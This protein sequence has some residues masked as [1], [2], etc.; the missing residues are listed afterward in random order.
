M[1]RELP[2]LW[3]LQELRTLQEEAGG[4][5]LHN[6]GLACSQSKLINIDQLFTVS[7][8][9]LST[10]HT[11]SVS[12]MKSKVDITHALRPTPIIAHF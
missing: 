12:M 6:Y 4:I 7:P 5:V 2:E 10:E 9:V 11:E 8:S 1:L 3:T